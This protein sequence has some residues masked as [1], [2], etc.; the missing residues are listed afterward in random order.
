[1]TEVR[2]YLY[3]SQRRV[4]AILE[5]IGAGTE[6]SQGSLKL[7]SPSG[8]FLPQAEVDRPART[9][10]RHDLAVR[11]ERH[12]AKATF[13]G[14]G[15]RFRFARGT[16]S[17]VFAEYA[18]GGAEAQDTISIFTESAAG[19]GRM[20]VCMFGSRDNL[21]DMVTDSTPAR[22]GW[23]SSAAPEV[24]RF[25]RDRHEGRSA[26]IADE[27][28]LAEAA[29]AIA[30]QQGGDVN[31]PSDR[32]FTYG[33]LAE[34]GEWMMEIY[35]DVDFGERTTRQGDY[36]RVLIGA[37]LWVRTPSLEAFVAYADEGGKRRSGLRAVFTRAA[38]GRREKP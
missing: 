7:R 35:H 38:A 32:G 28:D 36:R 15:G 10:T 33:H 18:G 20:A 37:P 26:L 22:R 4:R 2:R 23:S 17:T 21:A 1:M 24:H 12:L 14:Q 31:Q 27:F 5:D 8:P 16:G 19:P 9:P 30:C 3:W 29:V 13:T 6:P 34:V 11:V 25:I